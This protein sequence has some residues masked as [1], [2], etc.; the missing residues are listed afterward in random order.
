MT[1]LSLATT[2]FRFAALLAVSTV[3]FM[4]T[5]LAGAEQPPA[6]TSAVNEFL[7]RFDEIAARGF[8][9][10]QRRGATGV[11]H[12]LE[13]LL[14]LTENN[15]PRGDFRGIEVKAWRATSE[16]ADRRRPMN[17]FL[18]EPQ[19]QDRGT[20]AERIERFGYVDT[21]G[22]FAWYQ[23]VTYRENSG[24]LK[25]QRDDRAESLLLLDDAD[26]IGYWPYAVLEKR[27]TEKHEQAVFVGA[28]ARGRGA[29]EEFHYRSVV[30]CQHP[31]L[32][33]FLNIAENGDIVVELRMHIKETGSV[34]NHGT[35]FRIR[36]DRIGDLYE[37]RS[38]QR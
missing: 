31:S 2:R 23:S 7:R 1:I 3:S 8:V 11:G 28:V 10:T 38:V 32:E 20:T 19:W 22:H 14:G 15:D 34:R 29:S 36:K 26:A 9:P 12:T 37:S 25:L 35:A 6:P 16:R 27:L 33:R 24:G 18:K 17:L 13:A 5:A 4:A 30:W 21:K